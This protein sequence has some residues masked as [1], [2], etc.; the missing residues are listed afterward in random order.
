M[1]ITCTDPQSSTLKP[2]IRYERGS[3]LS[4]VIYIHRI[5]DKRFTGI[6]GRNF[7]MF[8]ELCGD[9]TLQNVILVTNMWSEVSSEIGESR[10]NE[11]SSRFFKPVIDKGAQM[12]RHHNTAQSAHDIIRLIMKNR[13]AALQIQREL[14]DEHKDIGDTAAGETINKELNEQMR[15]H[16][17]EMKA[18]QQEMRQAL[19]EKDE[20]TRREL[21]EETRRLQEQMNRIKQDSTGMASNYAAEKGRMEVRM[22]E[23]E[24]EAK[25]EKQRAEADHNRQVA[26]L[27]RRL[28]ETSSASRAERERMEGEIRRL[29]DE[30]DD[31]DDYDSDYYDRYSRAFK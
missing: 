5:S 23:M 29:Q 15:R 19:K 3:K 9:T 16:Q 17:A 6:A 18:V 24:Q 26:D 7:K 1:S 8:R 21:E 25:R 20:E 28:Q 22:R 30:S 14:V 4:G 2:L 27:N 10:E 31:S 12:V 11:L 13:P